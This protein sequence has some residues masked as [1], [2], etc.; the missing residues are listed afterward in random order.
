MN[1]WVTG[2]GVIGDELV[3]NVQNSTGSGKQP[4][5]ECLPVI[6]GSAE[7]EDSWLASVVAAATAYQVQLVTLAQARDILTGEVVSSCP[8]S[9]PGP[10]SFYC[11]YINYVRVVCHDFGLPSFA[12][13]AQAKV[14]GTTGVRDLEGNEKQ[15]VYAT[16]QAARAATGLEGGEEAVRDGLRRAA[17]RAARGE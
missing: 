11:D 4:A 6:A 16:L 14:T 13:E 1:R 10:L 8:C 2:T 12:C 17:A 7:G 5:P 3:V 15:P 9:A